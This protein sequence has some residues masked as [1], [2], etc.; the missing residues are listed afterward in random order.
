MFRAFSEHI[1]M[2]IIPFH[3][4]QG[5]DKIKYALASYQLPYK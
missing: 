3:R 1:Q 2:P 4:L 5:F